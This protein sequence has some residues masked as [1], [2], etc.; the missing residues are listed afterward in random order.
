MHA[1]IMRIL[2]VALWMQIL[3]FCIYANTWMRSGIIA[4]KWLF[5]YCFFCF[6][7]LC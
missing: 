6:L 5:S 1:L 4:I 2:V 7:L 3:L